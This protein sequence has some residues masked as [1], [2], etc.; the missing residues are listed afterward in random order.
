MCLPFFELNRKVRI[1]IDLT[2]TNIYQMGQRAHPSV[3]EPTTLT[4]CHTLPCTERQEWVRQEWVVVHTIY[5]HYSYVDELGFSF[6]L[7]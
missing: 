3:G 5:L 1:V 4:L 2:I 6:F 7:L